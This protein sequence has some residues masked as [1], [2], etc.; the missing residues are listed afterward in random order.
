M[1]RMTYKLL[2]CGRVIGETDLDYAGPGRTQRLALFRPTSEGQ[3]QLPRITGLLRATFA[4][5]QALERRGLEPEDMQ[6]EAVIDVL[7][8]TPEGRRVMEVAKALEALELRDERGARLDFTSIAVSDLDEIQQL[9][10][11]LETRAPSARSAVPESHRYL[12][13]ATLTEDVAA[14]MPPPRS[15]DTLML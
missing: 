3:Q 2:L 8:R 9:S 13:S 10:E 11:E 7:E 15:T 6:A 5:K 12:I 4:L 14:R 1:S